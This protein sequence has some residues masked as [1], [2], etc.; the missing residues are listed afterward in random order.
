MIRISEPR[1][2][3]KE[4]EGFSYEPRS[5]TVIRSTTTGRTHPAEVVTTRVTVV[6]PQAQQYYGFEE[7]DAELQRALL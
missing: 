3:N 7:E 2:L 5:A 1:A 4:D 6:Q